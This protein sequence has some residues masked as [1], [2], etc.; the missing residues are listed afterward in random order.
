[1]IIHG[2]NADY[3]SDRPDV[4]VARD[5]NDTQRD[6]AVKDMA[7][8]KSANLSQGLTPAFQGVSM[9]QRTVLLQ[10]AIP[11]SLL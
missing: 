1:M 11:V 7:L 10:W 8:L 4:R 5:P 9:G 2:A 3:L 6:T